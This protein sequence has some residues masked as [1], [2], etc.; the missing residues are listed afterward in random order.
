MRGFFLQSEPCLKNNR[1]P[2]E[3]ILD[4][5]IL[6]Y[7]ISTG[8]HRHRTLLGDDQDQGATR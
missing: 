4:A 8:Y 1:A 7:F 5:R 2:L 6:V 3:L